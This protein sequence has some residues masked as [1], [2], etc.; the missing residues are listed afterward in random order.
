MVSLSNSIRTSNSKGIELQGIFRVAGAISKVRELKSAV[1]KAGGKLSV[2]P[3]WVQ[4]H[5]VATLYK[6]YFRDMKDPLIPRRF[7]KILLRTVVKLI[8]I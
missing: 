3:D 8:H 4:P 1:E 5:D 2:F 6:A 7:N